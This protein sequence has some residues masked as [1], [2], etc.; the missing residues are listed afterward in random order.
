MLDFVQVH[1]Y[2]L[3]IPILLLLAVLRFFSKRRRAKQEFEE[4]SQY[5]RRDDALAEALRNPQ[6]KKESGPKGP[7]E[8]TWDDKAI[9]GRRKKHTSPMVE[10]I[11]LSAYSRKKFVFRLEQPI[12][13][14]SGKDNQLE[15]LR[16]GVEESHCEIFL[17]GE[18]VCVRSL[19]GAKTILKRGK[20]S[21]LISPAGVYLNSGDSIQLGTVEIRIRLFRG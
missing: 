3:G 21:A 2:I 13:I 11:E 12:R 6:V 10:L 1:L 20:T 18:E 15:L 19:S 7:M 9:S 17:N 14:G 4:M 8:I 5:K 16:E